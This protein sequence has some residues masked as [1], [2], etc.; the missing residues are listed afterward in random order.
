MFERLTNMDKT[1]IDSCRAEHKRILTET[2]ELKGVMSQPL[3]VVR[4]ARIWLLLSQ[5][6]KDLDTH[7]ARENELI[8]TARRLITQEQEKALDRALRDMGREDV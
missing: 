6:V 8:S 5:I 7:L 2:D 3:D 4:A 1:L